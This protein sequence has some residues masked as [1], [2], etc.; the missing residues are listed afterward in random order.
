MCLSFLELLKEMFVTLTFK[1]VMYKSGEPFF[2]ER[3]VIVMRESFLGNCYTSMT[4]V[5]E[6]V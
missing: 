4:M 3:K 5:M 6:L 1:T 2:K